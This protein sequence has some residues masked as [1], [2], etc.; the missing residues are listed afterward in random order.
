MNNKTLTLKLCYAFLII[1]SAIMLIYYRILFPCNNKWYVLLLL[2]ISFIS[3]PISLNRFLKLFKI[4]YSNIFW[5]IVISLALFF[6]SFNKSNDIAISEIKENGGVVKV[7]VV[8]KRYSSIQSSESISIKYIVEGKSISAKYNCSKS[9][10]NQLVVG[11]TILIV[12]SLKCPEWNLP[13]NYFPTSKDILQC[14]EGCLIENG[15][16]IISD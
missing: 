9:I 13:F 12:Y 6:Y 5:T 7:A 14:K 2:G 1:I 15:R 11:D 8:Y 16:L 4:N 3:F 10:Y